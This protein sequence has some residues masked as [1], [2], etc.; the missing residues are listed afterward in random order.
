MTNLSSKTRRELVLDA[1]RAAE[2]VDTATLSSKEVGGTEGLRRLRE[3][4]NAGFV[5][6]KRRKK[7]SD[8]F[9][10]HLVTEEDVRAASIVPEAVAGAIGRAI[11]EPSFTAD[12]VT[13][14]KTGGPSPAPARSDPA[15]RS[16]P[17]VAWHGDT[18]RGFT[19]KHRG[20]SLSV[21]PFWGDERW[22]WVV[23]RPDG[24]QESGVAP[25]LIAAKRAALE[26]A[27]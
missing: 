14:E 24:K 16:L 10:Y 15:A 25:T 11:T 3:L 23:T 7:G 13:M 12:A 26:V 5:I 19:S 9:E 1:L 2:W 21:R 27:L 20:H 8:Q 17:F 18:S 22:V 4:R 6:D